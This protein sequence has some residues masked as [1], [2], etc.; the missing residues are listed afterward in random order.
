LTGNRVLGDRPCVDDCGGQSFDSGGGYWS[1][2]RLPGLPYLAGGEQSI[3]KAI[4]RAHSGACGGSNPCLQT[5]AILTVLSTVPPDNGASVL[6][7]PY[8]GTSKPLFSTAALDAQIP[9]LPRLASTPTIDADL[10]TLQAA[11]ENVKRPDIGY[12]FEEINDFH[13]VD[14]VRLSNPYAP[15]ISGVYVN[16]VLRALVATAGDSETARRDLL[17]ALTQRGIDLWAMRAIGM[18]WYAAGGTNFGPRGPIA[19]AA[20]MLDNHT[21]TDTIAG[22]ARNDFQETGSIQASRRADHQPIWGQDRGGEQSYWE[23]VNG[24]IDNRTTWDPYGYID[25][26]YAPSTSY[27]QCCLSAAL[28]GDALIVHLIPGMTAIWNDPLTLAY[29]NRWV[30]HGMLTSHDPCAPTTQGGGPNGTGGCQLDPDLTP[31]STITTFT[32]QTGKQCGRFPDTDG[33]APDGTP[34]DW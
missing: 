19:F 3:V 10:P 5:A 20:R 30:T 17:I 8:V 12:H 15:G 18:H 4:S 28:K 32:C 1:P 22:S 27:Q 13:P 34:G 25:G 21:I 29:T 33:L 24:K 16:S 2:G 26:A 6:R 9:T 11:L 7:P 23:A 14:A 31:G